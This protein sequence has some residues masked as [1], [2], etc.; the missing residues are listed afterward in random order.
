MVDM[1]KVTDLNTS[2]QKLLA[3]LNRLASIAPDI[4]RAK[5]AQ[6]DAYLAVG[7]TKEQALG[8]IK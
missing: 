2:H 7:F 5:K 8:L 3:E 1:S 4:A 6:Y